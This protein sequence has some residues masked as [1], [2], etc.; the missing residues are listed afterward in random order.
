MTK[1]LM[2]V[3]CG[4]FASGISSSSVWLTPWEACTP[5]QPVYNLASHKN[6]YIICNLNNSILDPAAD[7]IYATVMACTPLGFSN[8]T[9]GQCLPGSDSYGCI[10]E[11]NGG[12]SV[13]N[14]T[15]PET[16]TNLGHYELRLQ[17]WSH[18]S[19]PTEEKSIANLTIVYDTSLH[20][21][22]GEAY[23]Q[24]AFCEKCPKGTSS[25]GTSCVVC[26]LGA[27]GTAEGATSCTPCAPGF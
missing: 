10:F 4:L 5:I 18:A 27:T 17:Y 14:I 26:P 2:L 7:M 9:W 15:I 6:T 24:N 25:N 22:P 16:W 3:L 11:Y 21:P 19:Y 12:N 1:L 8:F 23:Q 13:C 20:C